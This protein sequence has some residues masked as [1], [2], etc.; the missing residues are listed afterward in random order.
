VAKFSKQEKSKNQ[1]T[2]RQVSKKSG[3]M[4]SWIHI[5]DDFARTVCGVASV[6]DVTPQQA[7][8]ILP[9]YYDSP[10]A[11]C[12]ITDLTTERPVVAP[13]DF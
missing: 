2:A 1:F 5:T 9:R 3:R 6:E 13:E 7:M 8:D 10:L 12:V 11:E 4:I